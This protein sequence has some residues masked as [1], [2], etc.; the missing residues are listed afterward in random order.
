M[1]ETLLEYCDS[2]GLALAVDREAGILRGVKLVGL[3][4]RN[5]RSYLPEA[6]VR[7]VELYEGA[8]VNVDHPKGHAGQPRDYRDR[9]GVIRG[10][11]LGEGG[12]F[13]DLHFNPRHA[14]AGQL[15]W[16]AEHS[17]ENVGFSHNV[18][19][20]T[21]QKNGRTLVEEIVEVQ[22]VDLVADPATTRGLFESV[23][24]PE[25][26]E[27]TVSEITL[28]EIK[29]QPQVVHELRQEIA[30]ESRGAGMGDP[31]AMEPSQAAELSRLRAEN[32]ALRSE[33]ALL[34][35][36][37]ATE[38]RLF[39]ARL[40]P[41]ALSELFFEQL[42]AADEAGQQ[43]LIEDRRQLLRGALAA[44]RG[45]RSRDQQAVEGRDQAAWPSDARSFAAALR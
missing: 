12:I 19:A 4:S 35:K 33:Q 34:A 41:E 44:D 27:Q 23:Q 40:P 10:A 2:R 24:M 16:D 5:N 36:R 22:S 39:E 29:A 42:L 8:K 25:G 21:S 43:R 37:A 7:A 28:D 15:S 38:R 9:L 20:R 1:H 30:A 26:K 11:R 32:D 17:P 13:A 45:P 31:G 6:L 18:R 14:L 3:E